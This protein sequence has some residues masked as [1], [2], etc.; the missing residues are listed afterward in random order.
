MFVLL[1]SVLFI[2][3]FKYSFNYLRAQTSPQTGELIYGFIVRNAVLLNSS[4]KQTGMGFFSLYT[5]KNFQMKQLKYMKITK[6][7]KQKNQTKEKKTN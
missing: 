6:A 4:R 1:P 7:N 3:F 5:V 2:H